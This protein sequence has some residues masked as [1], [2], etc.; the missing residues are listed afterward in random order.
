MESQAR[1]WIQGRTGEKGKK[2]FFLWVHYFD[3]HWPYDPP[4]DFERPFLHEDGGMYER[5]LRRFREGG[6]PREVINFT[7]PLDA[8]GVQAGI[9]AYDDEAAY[10]DSQIGRLL[11]W[12][13]ER[14]LDERTLVAVVSDHGESLGEHDLF[15]AHSF[16]LYDEIERVLFLI[17]P[18]GGRRP[19]RIGKQVRLLDFTPTVLGLLGLGN[20]KGAEGRDLSP[21]WTA[22]E[23]ALPDA[24]AYA[25][26]EEWPER[27][28]GGR[29]AAA[30]GRRP[31][32]IAGKWRMV[33]FKGFKLLWIPG[34]GW[35]LYD[36]VKDPRELHDLSAAPPP[37]AR[38]LAPILEEFVRESS[39][40][41]GSGGPASSPSPPGLDEDARRELEEVLRSMGYG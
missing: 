6:L 22:G 26:S 30:N 21:L 9:A 20:V 7:P 5:L 15:F 12:L 18:P 1:E 35:E 37:A 17:R 38:S 2:P 24:P 29:Y 34:T 11:G 41:A 40:S 14:G 10:A 25:E 28:P 4:A 31:P 39:V 36:L 19:V 27:V 32:G 23:D 3:P 13:E 33:R 16:T 8:D